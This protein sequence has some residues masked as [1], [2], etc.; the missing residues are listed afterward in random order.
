MKK[1]R[2]KT[3]EDHYCEFIIPSSYQL[4]LVIR[5]SLWRIFF[6]KA[7]QH[8]G[9]FTLSYCF[10]LL[11]LSTLRYREFL[12]KTNKKKSMYFRALI[13]QILLFQPHKTSENLCW[14]LCSSHNT[15]HESSLRFHIWPLLKIDKCPLYIK[16]QITHNFFIQ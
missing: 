8:S 11:H 16:L 12:Q 4:S 1:E 7:P 5:T 9:N 13:S 10:I 14:F 2:K 3:V 6:S 15:L